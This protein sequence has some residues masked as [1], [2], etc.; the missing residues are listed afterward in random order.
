M[1]SFDGK[2]FNLKLESVVLVVKMAFHICALERDRVRERDREGENSLH[3][4]ELGGV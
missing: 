4:I 2:L 1:L 3:E